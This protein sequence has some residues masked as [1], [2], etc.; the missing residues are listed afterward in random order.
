MHRRLTALAAFVALAILPG[1]SLFYGSVNCTFAEGN[2]AYADTVLPEY[3]AYIDADPN[4]DAESK[5]IRKETADKWVKL[6]DDALTD[7][8]EK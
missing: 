5:S 3:K 1:C 4:L 8:K 7:C 6:I 2:K